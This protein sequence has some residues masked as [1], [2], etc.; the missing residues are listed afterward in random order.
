MCKQSE[1]LSFEVSRIGDLYK[2]L[3]VFSKRIVQF[4]EK[5]KRLLDFKLGIPGFSLLAFNKGILVTKTK[6]LHSWQITS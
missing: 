1:F 6:V 2:K 4:Q 3:F 5:K